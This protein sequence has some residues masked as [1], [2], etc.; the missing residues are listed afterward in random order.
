[1]ADAKVLHFVTFHASIEAPKAGEAALPTPTLADDEYVDMINIMFQS[2]VQSNSNVKFSI[3]TNEQ[4][5]LD[6]VTLPFSRIDGEVRSSSLMLDRA[7][8]QLKAVKQIARDEVMIFLDSD[9]LVLGDLRH[10]LKHDFDIGLTV[11]HSQTMPINGGIIIANSKYPA[12]VKSF[13][14]EYVR[15]YSQDYGG[16]R[17]WYGDQLALRKL[18]EFHNLSQIDEVRNLTTRFG[19]VLFLPCEVYNYSPRDEAD[20]L[21]TSADRRL[22]H[23]K[24]ARKTFMKS[25]WRMTT[26]AGDD[27]DPHFNC[28]QQDAP[29]WR[30][31]AVQGAGL[32]AS[33]GDGSRPLSIADL[34]CGDMK[35]KSALDG[36]GLDF[37]YRGY[38]IQP[39]DGSVVAFDVTIDRLAEIVDVSA[40]LGVIEYI[41]VAEQ[42]LRQVARRSRHVLVT[43]IAADRKAY[44]PEKIAALGWINHLTRLELETLCLKAGLVPLKRQM[45]ADGKTSVLL[46]KSTI[47]EPEAGG[48]RETT[49]LSPYIIPDRLKG[50][51]AVNVGDGFIL[52]GLERI[53]GFSDPRRVFSPRVAPAAAALNRLRESD[54]VLLAGANQLHD[55]FAVWPGLKAE[56][57]ESQPLRFVPVG[58]GVYGDPARNA[59]MSDHTKRTLR[60]IHGKIAFSS[61]RCPLSVEYLERE[62][63]DLAGRFLMTGCPAAFDAPLLEGSAFEDRDDEIA[64]TITERGDWWDRERTTLEYVARRFPAARRHLVLHQDFQSIG[65]A[66]S[67]K[68]ARYEAVRQVARDLGYEI[69]VPVSA[70]DALLFYKRIGMH[71]GSRVHAHLCMLSQNKRSFV[72][73]VDDRATGLAQAYDFPICDPTEFDR[74]LG[75][76]FEGVRRAAQAAFINMRRFVDALE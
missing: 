40:L 74:H 45:T 26:T 47:V 59:A 58:I 34:G 50:R 5:K 35:L 15:L 61:W 17:K 43:A 24:G 65:D 38:D 42:A 71:F 64:V 52:R 21:A 22:V 29:S 27:A 55:E 70:D 60:A 33:L 56:D 11:R 44:S 76:D 75:M 10:L 67:R 72:T 7:R 36:R 48:R 4:T 25:V 63:P 39:Q 62:L 51:K 49:V 20:A 13:F 1:M 68:S 16:E 30:D 32:I 14:Q 73:R 2:I 28:A 18:L 57:I 54:F 3:I 12:V 37:T 53:F 41:E 23:F 19:N 31:R 66:A 46:C 9:I 6:G 8:A 69:H